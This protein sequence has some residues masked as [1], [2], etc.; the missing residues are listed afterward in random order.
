MKPVPIVIDC[1]PGVDDSFAIA[2]AHAAP[3]YEI[4]A[5]TAV[6]G[7]V[8]AAVTR[9][10]ALS[11]ADVFGI[12]CRVA[13]GAEQPLERACSRDASQVHGSSGMG[14]ISLAAPVRKPDKAAA[15]D[16]IYEEAVKANGT[17]ILFALGPLTNI[18]MALRHHPDLPEYLDKLCIMGGGSF[19]NVEESG[20]NAEFNL[21]VDPTA[22]REVFAKMTVWMVGLDCTH[23]AALT[24]EE[25]D[26]M[27]R[28]CAMTPRQ[29]SGFLKRLTEFS[30]RN[31]EEQGQD[32][33]IIHDAVAIA[34]VIDPSLVCF[35]E[36][37]AEIEADPAAINAGQTILDFENKDGRRI[38]CHAAVQVDRRRF[39][40]LMQEMCRKY[41]GVDSGDLQQK[42]G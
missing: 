41:S 5:I 14:D 6:E 36:C 29:Q 2:L 39:A 10:N 17:L 24:P 31:S 30:K 27:I 32:N 33:H 13:F 34:S 18:A 16:V 42:E 26:E 11:I 25:L 20:G 40:L 3:G 1:D 4:R 23:C 22:A 38:N 19:G 9:K 7:N 37:H 21:W 28:I 8:P 12:D 15:W 35:E